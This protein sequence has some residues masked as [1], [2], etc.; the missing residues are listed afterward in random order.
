MA[1]LSSQ[2][3]DINARQTCDLFLAQL[4]RLQGVTSKDHPNAIRAALVTPPV[5]DAQTSPPTQRPRNDPKR[6][7]Q[8]MN[9]DSSE[10][11]R[12]SESPRRRQ[13]STPKSSLSGIVE[14]VGSILT[15]QPSFAHFLD[16]KTLVYSET[17]SPKRDTLNELRCVRSSV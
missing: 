3:Y 4:R 2:I 5:S 12:G 17:L 14:F 10:C 6:K 16:D 8:E 13:R 15:A 1:R 9:T 7:E 11:Q